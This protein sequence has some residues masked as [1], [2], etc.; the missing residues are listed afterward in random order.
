MKNN[1]IVKS[2]VLAKANAKRKVMAMLLGFATFSLAVGG[3]S[4]TAKAQDGTPAPVQGSWLTAIARI[5]S[6]RKLPRSDVL[7]CGRRVASD[8]FKQSAEWGCFT[9]VRQLGAHWQKSLQLESV[10]LRF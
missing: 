10:F 7:E 3:M 8:R 9:P 2:L 5:T 6:R 1:S 4:S